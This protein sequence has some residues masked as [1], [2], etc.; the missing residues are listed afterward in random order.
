M[1]NKGNKM[2]VVGNVPRVPGTI[3]LFTILCEVGHC[4][5][6]IKQSGHTGTLPQANL[7]GKNKDLNSAMVSVPGI[8]EHDGKSGIYGTN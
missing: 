3:K 2:K 6:V 7:K 8:W 1:K 5:G 4:K